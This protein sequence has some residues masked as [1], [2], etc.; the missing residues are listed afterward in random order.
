MTKKLPCTACGALILPTT[1]V[2]TRG[3]CMPC[4]DDPL[5][6]E[7]GERKRLEATPTREILRQ[8]EWDVRIEVT[9]AAIDAAYKPSAGSLSGFFLV[10]YIFSNCNV[11]VV[12]RAEQEKLC[13]E[14]ARWNKWSPHEFHPPFYDYDLC[15]RSNH[16]LMPLDGRKPEDDWKIEVARIFIRT[17]RYVRQNIITDPAVLVSIMDY[18]EGPGE[19]F[20]SYSELFNGAELLQQ[21]RSDLQPILD[22]DRLDL[23]RSWIPN[24]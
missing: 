7:R 24:T 20:F 1:A 14:N 9:A 21:L 22:E 8:L 16:H 23:A 4:F 15:P 12:T 2:K 5:Y 13:D 3:L 11:A 6:K 10:H 17:M 18:S 19:E